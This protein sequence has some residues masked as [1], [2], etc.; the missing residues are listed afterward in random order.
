VLARVGEAACCAQAEGAITTERSR[1]IARHVK[2]D[3]A[4]RCPRGC[5]SGDLGAKKRGLRE[6]R[7]ALSSR[8]AEL[9]GARGQSLRG[10][11]R[12]AA[13]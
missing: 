3:G 1:Q 13:Q 7:R 11:R 8:A 5:L 10:A 12:C 2:R 9:A 6:R 4:G